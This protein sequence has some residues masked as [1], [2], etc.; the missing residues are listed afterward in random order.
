[1]LLDVLEQLRGNLQKP[2]EAPVDSDGAGPAKEQRIVERTHWSMQ[3]WRSKNWP[4]QWASP[5]ESCLTRFTHS[6]YLRTNLAHW[7]RH[8]SS[9]FPFGSSGS[10]SL[11]PP[12]ASRALSAPPLEAVPHLTVTVEC[13]HPPPVHCLQS[14]T[15]LL[16]SSFLFPPC[17]NASPRRSARSL[18]RTRST[19]SRLV[20]PSCSAANQ[21]EKLGFASA[22]EAE[23]AG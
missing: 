14:R 22:H 23:Q 7:G 15:P 5:E 17:Q 3:R 1:M 8:S 16:R 2:R 4:V 6:S 12:A 13:V 19:P 18:A 11:L 20:Q 10:S 9:I 21:G